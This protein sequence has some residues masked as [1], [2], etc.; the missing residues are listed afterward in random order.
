MKQF[1]V[2]ILAAIASAQSQNGWMA[3]NMVKDGNDYPDGYFVRSQDWST[4]TV[5]DKTLT[6]GG[7]NSMAIQLSQTEDVAANFK[8]YV[9]GGSI[10]YD[11]N[12]SAVNSG[13]VAGV[14]MVET[15]GWCDPN[16]EKGSSSQC[17]SIDAM[18]ANMYGFETAANP[19][20]NGTCDAVSQCIIGM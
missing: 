11:V 18:N 5:Q 14:Y 17:K 13:C 20:S 16:A 10:Q 19:C 2:A 3:L 6:I 7:N 9:R 4:A 12:L 8:P 15:D 1:A